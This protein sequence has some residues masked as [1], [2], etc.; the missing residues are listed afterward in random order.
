MKLFEQDKEYNC[1]V[2]AMKFFLELIGIT[3]DAEELEKIMEATEADGTS[4]EGMIK[5]FNFYDIIPRSF[6]D[7]AVYELPNDRPFI[8]NY[9]WDGDGHYA[10][11]LGKIKDKFIIYNPG[12]GEI[13]I[14]NLSIDNWYSERYGKRWAIT[15]SDFKRHEL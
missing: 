1:G 15:F 12:N 8:I 7:A 9:Q 5:A 11:V 6:N 2:Y 10:V 13:E 3:C 4:H 14:I